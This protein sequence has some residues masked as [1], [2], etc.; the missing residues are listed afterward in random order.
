MNIVKKI[1]AVALSLVLSLSI[2]PSFNPAQA[3]I[4]KV[5]V[6]PNSHIFDS[7]VITTDGSSGPN[8]IDIF[9]VKQ[10]KFENS[11]PAVPEYIYVDVYDPNKNDAFYDPYSSGRV[12]QFSNK[13][14]NAWSIG[15][16]FMPKKTE[17][18]SGTMYIRVASDNKMANIIEQIPVS[19]S[20]YGLPNKPTLKYS[21]PSL[22]FGKIEVG[23]SITKEVLIE[24]LTP[25]IYFLSF[26]C[27]SK[28]DS[29]TATLE[30]K[31]LDACSTNS[32]LSVDPNKN[33][34][35]FIKF[36]PKD[37]KAYSESIV[38]S[39]NDGAYPTFKISVVGEGIKVAEQKEV[40]VAV[41]E[42]TTIITAASNNENTTNSE[43]KV[44]KQPEQLALT[45]EQKNVKTDESKNADTK[46]GAKISDN[47]KVDSKIENSERS[48]NSNEKE[49]EKINKNQEAQ[50][51]TY[52]IQHTS[53]EQ[54][55]SKKEKIELD[56]NKKYKLAVAA[57]LLIVLVV[58]GPIV[59]KKLGDKI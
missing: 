13:E 5:V 59:N 17:G 35:L 40:I 2:S 25:E 28:H 16:G 45:E 52:D 53:S 7:T 55:S 58:A 33:K 20:G 49:F 15:L 46:N 27:I 57:I 3:G 31:T 8:D 6:S 42:P 19:L 21:P 50:N 9:I 39:S 23:K 4:T 26:K 10:P 38:F 37:Q 54:G 43:N 32:D 22:Y 30:G 51:T 1:T 11:N 12:V 36:K 47:K 41:P 34:L 18:Q 56:V 44:T 24:N 14:D 29:F 48:N